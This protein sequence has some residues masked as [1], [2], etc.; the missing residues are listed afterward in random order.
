VTPLVADEISRYVRLAGVDLTADR[1]RPGWL[2]YLIVSRDASAA[3]A[4]AVRAAACR[5]GP[6]ILVI[7]TERGESTRAT[8][9]L[10]HAG[11]GDVIE[12]ND[13][14]AARLARHCAR[15]D[16]LGVAWRDGEARFASGGSMAGVREA[17]F[18]GAADVAPN[19]RPAQAD[20][21]ALQRSA[22]MIS[23]P[24]W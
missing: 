1:A 21:R 15:H 6:R 9:R 23:N 17:I 22:R 7:T 5:V 18:A 11:A 12:W 3:A 13:D 20:D 10:L 8:W 2:A 24:S 4:A 16:F 14:H 19:D